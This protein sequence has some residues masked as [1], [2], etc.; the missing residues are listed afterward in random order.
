M[1]GLVAASYG[2]YMTAVFETWKKVSMDDWAVTCPY[3]PPV[4]LDDIDFNRWTV[5]GLPELGGN[6]FYYKGPARLTSVRTAAPPLDPHL[7]FLERR[8]N[9]NAS[10]DPSTPDQ[11]E[12]NRAPSKRRETRDRSCARYAHF[13]DLIDEPAETK[14]QNESATRGRPTE[15]TH[16]R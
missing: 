3:P 16:R 8:N 9:K 14:G 11:A 6:G 13:R 15:R 7:F 4:D 1:V 5:D 2:G 12:T 10:I